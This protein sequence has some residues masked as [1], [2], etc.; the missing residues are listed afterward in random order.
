VQ[1]ASVREFNKTGPAAVRGVTR[2]SGV[3][4]K[5]SWG[6]SFSGIWWSFVFGVR[7]LWRHNLTSYSC[8]QTNVLAKFVDIIGIFFYTRSLYFMCHCIEYN[9]SALQVT[10][11]EENKINATTQQ[12]ITAKMSFYVLKQGSKTHPSLRQSNLQH[13]NETA[14]MSCR[15][16]AVEHRC[17]AGLGVQ[18]GLQDRILLNYTRIE[19]AHKVRKITFKFLLCI[20]AQQ[21]FSFSLSLLRHHQ[22]P[23]CFYV[24]NCCFWA[25][26]TILL[27][28]INW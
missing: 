10:I 1:R 19:N 9:V 15:T 13:K 14:L 12:F 6:V 28:W 21:T 23:E 8:F 24:K 20:E 26:A 11:S 17:G 22:M 3:R 27:C 16:R 4:R 25:R 7:C 2:F 5:F 18:P